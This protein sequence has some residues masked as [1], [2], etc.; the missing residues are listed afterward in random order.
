MQ[1]G[2]PWA[3]SLPFAPN[4]DGKLRFGIDEE[5]EKMLKTFDKF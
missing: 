2:P 1:L 3:A 5:W 4:K